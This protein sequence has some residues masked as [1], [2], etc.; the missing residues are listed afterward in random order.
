MLINPE[1]LV[2]SQDIYIDGTSS[3]LEM[4][5]LPY[6]DGEQYDIYD[7]KDYNKYINDIE[8][9][10]RMSYEYRALISYLKN[11][12][13]MNTCSF[14]SN[15][16]S[17][18]S[19]K[20]KI[21]IHHSPLSLW[22]I[23]ATVVK[24]RIHCKESID[25]FD[26]AKEIM[27]LHYIGWVGL[28]PVSE[29]VHEMIHNSYL[30]VPITFVRGNWREFINQYYDYIDPDTLDYINSAEILTNEW[31]AGN[32]TFI[33]AQQNLFNIHQTYV[34]FND[35]NVVKNIPDA[36]DIVKDRISDI[37]KMPRQM[38]TVITPHK[39]SSNQGGQK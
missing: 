29:T 11:T 27:W 26:C 17:D 2:Q 4:P 5:D 19:S 33:N 30:F 25:V 22:D 13:G 9:I 31:L 39:K 34:R 8:R 7:N 12:E 1:S 10:V 16:A 38:C 35:R 18:D 14:L 23:T 21:E 15:V 37:K 20:V 32:Q 28:Y 24:K 3:V 36:R 6:F